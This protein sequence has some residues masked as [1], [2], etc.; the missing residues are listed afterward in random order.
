MRTCCYVFNLWFCFQK[1]TLA[2]QLD[3]SCFTVNHL[4]TN[5]RCLIASPMLCSHPSIFGASPMC[6]SHSLMFCSL[7]SLVKMG[8]SNV[9]L[10]SYVKVGL[11]IVY[12]FSLSFFLQDV[13]MHCGE[14]NQRNICEYASSICV[15]LLFVDQSVF[16]PLR[17]RTSTELL[18]WTSM[19]L[20]ISLVLS[21][22][23]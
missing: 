1:L 23:K 5:L 6:C 17:H 19:L 21:R 13:R 18:Y 10:F 9:H 14:S 15:V 20:Y 16:P 2:Q 4:F 3:L 7:V 12:L 11:S 8:P 22:C